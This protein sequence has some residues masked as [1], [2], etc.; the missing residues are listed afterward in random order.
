MSPGPAKKF[1]DQRIQAESVFVQAGYHY[2]QRGGP[3]AVCT[4]LG[5]CV[6]ACIRDNQLGI[7]GLNHFL[8]PS[9]GDGDQSAR[10]GVNA[11]EL[12]IND[13][14]RLGASK[15]N[16]E[17]KIF[18]GASVMATSSADPVGQ[19]N[20]RFVQKYLN[21]EGIPI[22]AT[23]LGGTRARRVY[24]FPETGRASIL[25]VAPAD[26][27]EIQRTDA[28]LRSRATT[29]PSPGGVELF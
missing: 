22:L 15:E 8:L 19:Q 20:G 9:G 21:D 17:A 28:E 2:V 10:Y 13:I 7:G 5:S 16:L 4:F 27:K 29:A 11:M 3:G 14:L 1:F 18:G 6:A 23:D 12:L 26:S 24:F 25:H